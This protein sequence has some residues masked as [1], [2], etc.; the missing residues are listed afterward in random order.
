M[1]L[2]VIPR[3]ESHTPTNLDP[4]EAILEQALQIALPATPPVPRQLKST[5]FRTF[6]RRGTMFVGKKCNLRCHFC[7]YLD[8][9]E[10]RTHPEHEFLPLEK[11]KALCK[12]LVDVFGRNAVDIQGGEPTIY[13]HILPL[14][15][16]CNEIGLRPTLITNALVL[17]RMERVLEF[18]NAGVHDFLISVQGLGAVY[19]SVVGMEGANVR[20]LQ[21][22]RNVAEAGIPFRFN[23]VMTKAVVLHLPEIATLAVRTGAEVVNYLMYSPQDDQVTAGTRTVNNVPRYSEVR[24]R[25]VEALDILDAANIEANVRFF[26]Y[27]MVPERHRKSLYNYAQIQY[28]LHDWDFASTAWT[29][30]MPQRTTRGDIADPPLDVAPLGL[31]RVQLRLGRL[32]KVG[33][34]LSRIPG[35]AGTLAG[36]ERGLVAAATALRLGKA[37]E[38]SDVEEKAKA[39]EYAAAAREV[40]YTYAKC[41]DSCDAKPICDGLHSDSAAMFG[42]DDVQPI[43]L[44]FKA[45]DPTYYIRQ[46]AK[47]VNPRDEA[48]ALHQPGPLQVVALAPKA[49]RVFAQPRCRQPRPRAVGAPRLPGD[50]RKA[51]DFTNSVIIP[52]YKRPQSL[53]RTLRSLQEAALPNT[54][55]LVVDNADDPQ[56]A[57]A[58]EE[59][60][61]T[62]WCSARYLRHTENGVTG[63][64]HRAVHESRGE[65]LL[66][67]DDDA[68]F[69]SGWLSA[70][71]QAY[72]DYPEMAA[73]AGPVELAWDAPPP[74][75]LER[76]VRDDDGSPCPWR[77]TLL[78]LMTRPM[79]PGAGQFFSGFVGFYS[80]NMSMRREV[81]FEVGGFN[82]EAY[83]DVWLGD[84]ESGL[85]HKLWNHGYIVGYAPEA[86]VHHHIPPER[87]TVNYLCRRWA[88]E[89]ACETYTEFHSSPFSRLRLARYAAGTTVRNAWRWLKAWRLRGQTDCASLDVQLDAAMTRSRVRY[90][91]RLIFRRWARFLL[92]KDDWLNQH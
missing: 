1:K 21:G 89:G 72:A 15:E 43:R 81:F 47:V 45:T 19:D 71:L 55:I 9:V 83:G 68:T 61:R 73:A 92:L 31:P 84:G 79:F 13:P 54:E 86:Q 44:G 60:N 14:I 87:M 69:S 51:T 40:S 29:D 2:L 36:A 7:C 16:Y 48:W 22:I 88:N 25:L 64:R 62:A 77:H 5:A 85:S 70:H 82:P 28:D 75:W 12:T 18:K 59:Y 6:T 3:P 11:T 52:T 8:R 32:R 10:D 63:A 78:S 27:C 57:R 23:T 66:F 90:A 76:Y 65:I 33:E 26:P 80:V 39:M 50:F 17:D 37:L 38:V 35:V 58:V 91:L 42:T 67:T 53:A 30:D 74:P 24:D 49:P 20:Q 34:G 56:T 4:P 46:Q 41:C